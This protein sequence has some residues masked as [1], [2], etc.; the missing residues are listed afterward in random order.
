MKNFYSLTILFC[1][2]PIFLTAQDVYMNADDGQSIGLCTGTFQDHDPTTGLYFLDAPEIVTICSDDVN[3]DVQVD[4]TDFILISGFTLTIYDGDSTASP[5]IGSYSNQNSPG[6]VFPSGMN[7]SGCLTF[8]YTSDGS[9]FPGNA[10]GWEAEISCKEPCQEITPSIVSV[11]PSEY[12]AG[13]DTYTISFN[14]SILFQGAGNFEV[15]S[16][17]AT[18]Q[19]D[20]GNGDTATG[21]NVNYSYGETGTFTITLT[22]IDAFGCISEVVTSNVEV[23]GEVAGLCSEIR[24]FCAGSGELVFPNAHPGN[25]NQSVGEPGVDYGCLGS[26]P[27]PA[28]FYLQIENGGDLT[29]TIEQNTQ[30]NLNGTGLDVD[31][32]AWGPFDS[33]DNCNNLNSST[34]VPG[35]TG[36]PNDGCDFSGQDIETFGV[37]NTQPGE[38]YIIVITNYSQDAGFISM[39]QTGGVGSTDCSILEPVLGDDREICGAGTET[40]DAT[41]SG[42]TSYQWSVFNEATSNYDNLPGETNPTLDVSTSGIYQVQ[43]TDP[44]GSVFADVIEITF[45]DEPVF[46]ATI[47]QINTCNSGEGSTYNLLSNNNTFLGSQDPD[48]FNVIYYESQADAD[49]GTSPITD[50]E[51]YPFPTNDCVDLFVRI[52]NSDFTSCYITDNFELCNADI[53]VGTN[54]EDLEECDNDNDGFAI[55]DLTANEALALD[56]LDPAEFQVEYFESQGDAD[57]GTDAITTPDAFENT[58]A[59]GQTIY[60]RVSDT[61]EG[62]CNA[63]DNSF[64]ITALEVAET[65]EAEP[66]NFC[67][68]GGGE[69]VELTQNETT[70]LG[71][72]DP[73]DFSFSYYESQAEADAGDPATAIPDP[74]AYEPAIAQDCTSIYVRIENTDNADCFTTTS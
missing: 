38:I 44:E 47:G 53:N 25:S 18:Y 49:A 29:F 41:T 3:S 50:P 15:D 57:A 66:I 27:Y 72:Q 42:A 8:E 31:F 39:Q 14:Q 32:V 58:T 61:D 7:N 51:N 36:A 24:P 54:L 60:V 52:E 1:L 9:A 20:F 2:L 67:Y 17:G 34:Q 74:S 48:N 46:E 10:F 23:T 16:D 28:W 33:I 71:S 68:Q 37:T 26:E 19:W 40:L 13:T 59:G 6:T 12:D 45:Y 22:I 55:F 70:I 56:G 5:V 73:A 35:V 43:I 4:F 69:T 62:S 63:S 11:L 21:Q 65:N 64:E 30:A